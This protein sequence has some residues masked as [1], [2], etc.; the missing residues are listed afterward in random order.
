MERVYV[1]AYDS[2]RGVEQIEK[3][4]ASYTT[5]EEMITG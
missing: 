4:T 3:A 2:G 1:C 5:T